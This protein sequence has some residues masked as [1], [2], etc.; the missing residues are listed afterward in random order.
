MNRPLRF[1]DVSVLFLLALALCGGS[2]PA[3]ALDKGAA[4]PSFSL[5]NVN[6][7]TVSASD[8]SD[9][10]ALVVVF[11]SHT[12]TYSSAYEDRLAALQNE[13][14]GK[15]VRFVLINPNSADDQTAGRFESMQKRATEQKYPFPYLFDESRQTTSAFGATKTPEAFV[16]GA[17]HKLVYRGRIDDNTEA[18][19][20]RTHDLQNVLNLIVAGT[21][22]KISASNIASFGCSIKR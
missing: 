19:Q 1:W 10:I 21:P 3:W 12:C 15:G 7:K 16:F 22:D 5:K 2:M 9:K 6:G 13:F 8:F 20:V 18:K 11:A 14:G 4:L 17:D